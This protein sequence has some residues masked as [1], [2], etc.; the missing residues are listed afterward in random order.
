MRNLLRERNTVI[1]QMAETG[2]WRQ[3]LSASQVI[4]QRAGCHPAAGY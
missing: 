2:E 1:R 3:Y 4:G